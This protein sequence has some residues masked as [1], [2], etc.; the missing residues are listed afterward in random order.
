MLESFYRYELPVKIPNYPSS[1]YII[2]NEIQKQ[3]GA[4]Y[5]ITSATKPYA[6]YT[7]TDHTFADRWSL[8]SQ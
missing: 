7:F 8:I 2:V 1:V 5:K 3:S 4:K 6:T